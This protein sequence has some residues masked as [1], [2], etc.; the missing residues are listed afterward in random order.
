MARD[1]V[2]VRDRVIYIAGDM[3][4]RRATVTV[5]WNASVYPRGGMVNLR[6]DNQK[7]DETSISYDPKGSRP[8]S[9]HFE[10]DDVT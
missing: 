3:S 5:V 1:T 4:H 8:S 7:D 10:G 2:R 6:V 9:W